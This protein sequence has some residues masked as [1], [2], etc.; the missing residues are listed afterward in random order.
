MAIVMLMKWLRSVKADLE[1]SCEED[2]ADLK[3][4]I[5]DLARHMRELRWGTI[6]NAVS[7]PPLV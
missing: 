4:S 5:F 6:K 1:P 2:I 3:I 7:P